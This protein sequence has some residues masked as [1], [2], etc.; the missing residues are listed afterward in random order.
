MGYG[1]LGP[2]VIR[3]RWCALA[4]HIGSIFP[5][6]KSE[7]PSDGFMRRPHRRWYTQE[8]SAMAAVRL[9]CAVLHF[10]QG[11]R[12]VPP[13]VEAVKTPEAIGLDRL[14]GRLADKTLIT[15]TLQHH[16]PDI[17]IWLVHDF[18]NAK[19]LGA[20]YHSLR[21]AYTMNCPNRPTIGIGEGWSVL[22]MQAMLRVAPQDRWCRS[23]DSDAAEGPPPAGTSTR[24]FHPQA[25]WRQPLN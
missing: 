8:I 1:A 21:Y 9:W 13:R 7:R 17:K 24:Q 6:P 20:H 12:L 4:F 5:W 14:E 18:I 22:A 19:T 25:S 23:N 10:H 11:Y 3:S 15:K 2:Q 16:A